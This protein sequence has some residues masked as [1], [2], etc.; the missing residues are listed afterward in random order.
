MVLSMFNSNLVALNFSHL[1]SVSLPYQGELCL[2]WNW[3]IINSKKQFSQREQAISD[4]RHIIVTD[5]YTYSSIAE[6]CDY[7]IYPVNNLQKPNQSQQLMMYIMITDKL[8]TDNRV[9]RNSCYLFAA[10]IK[11]FIPTEHTYN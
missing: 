5:F 8:I 1:R 6:V 11:I 7:S 10:S 3:R 9:N 4:I 2:Y